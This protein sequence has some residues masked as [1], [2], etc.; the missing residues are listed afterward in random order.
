MNAILPNTPLAAKSSPV[1]ARQPQG[2]GGRIP[3]VRP[4]FM[5]DEQKQVYD[6]INASTVPWATNAGFRVK[7]D[8]GGLLGPYNS[9]LLNPGTDAG[10]LDMLDAEKKHTS[11][12]ERVREVII[13]SVGA[14][15]KADYEIY[16]HSAAGR[17]AG[18]SESAIRTLAAG[19]LPDDLD[20]QEKTA[21]RYAGQLSLERRVDADL[22]AEAERSF[23]LQGLADM[24][25]LIGIYHIVCGF[26]NSFEVPV[27]A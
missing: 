2:F 19:G 22:Y 6:R 12:S 10:Y 1:F 25:Y 7:A 9:Q 23:G 21:Q 3:L 11:L 20:G 27:P 24:I 17:T 14:V 4:D 5:S 16:A 26:L 18:L 13:L 15:W 8:G